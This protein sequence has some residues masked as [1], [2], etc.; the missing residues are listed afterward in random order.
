MESTLS[1]ECL[2]NIL[3]KNV[4]NKKRQTKELII[5]AIFWM[6][7]ISLYSHR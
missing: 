1:L 6:L 2:E 5:I 3:I 4:N 7:K